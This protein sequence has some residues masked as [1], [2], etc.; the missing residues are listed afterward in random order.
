MVL[1]GED[2]PDPERDAH[3]GVRQVG[4]DLPAGPLP[5][6]VAAREAGG[7]QTPRGRLDA[8]GA[9]P[10]ALDR[11]ALA[12]KPEDPFTVR[13]VGHCRHLN[14]PSCPPASY[15]GVGGG[16]YRP[17]CAN[18]GVP[19]PSSTPTLTKPKPPNPD[20]TVSILVEDDD[21]MGEAALIVILDGDGTP[22]KQVPTTIGG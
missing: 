3:L 1:L 5:R 11:V 4:E 17:A 16:A 18:G 22:M 20:S 14:P 2:L 15:H 13:A 8:L 10:Q 9:G 21:R 6:A 19:S 12:Q 7:A